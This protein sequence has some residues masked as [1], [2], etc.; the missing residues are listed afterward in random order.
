MNRVRTLMPRTAMRL[1]AA[2]GL[3]VTAAMGLSTGAASAQS[4]VSGSSQWVTSVTGA[5]NAAGTLTFGDSDITASMTAG[6]NGCGPG[7][8]NEI[9]NSEL[10][11]FNAD[12]FY[13]PSAPSDGVGV[14][15]CLPSGGDDRRVTFS[16]PLIDPVLYIDDLDASYL[17]VEQPGGGLVSLNTLSKDAPFN[18]IPEP[19]YT[20]LSDTYAEGTDPCE[21]TPQA[22]GNDPGCGS[23]QMSEASGPMSSVELYNV[24]K[25]GNADGWY[26]TLSFP[27]ATLTKAFSPSTIS[28]GGT[29][30]L[31]FTVSNPNNAGATNLGPLGVTDAFPTGLT[32]ADTTTSNDGN[33]GTPALTDG[34]GNALAAGDSSVQAA[35]VTVAT[36][37]TCTITVDVTAANTGSYTND[38]SNL[39]TTV[40]NLVPDTT[41]TLTVSTT[42]GTPM[43]NTEIAGLAAGGLLAVGLGVF[44]IRRQRR[45]GST[46]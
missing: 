46:A 43:A 12:A 31:T 15:Q 3:V 32:L 4:G 17:I 30:Q 35:G 29:S 8:T 20:E 5:Y 11:S 36:G 41:A 14:Q 22:P 33:C 7:G 19:T 13:T 34:S 40:G 6:N 10:V 27:T 28:P 26:W 23:F 16:Q 45:S 38:D 39:S 2:S 24:S 18:V 1:A 21:N 37:E 42:V 9:P 25:A 44:G